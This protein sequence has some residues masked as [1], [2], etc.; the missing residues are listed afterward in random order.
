MSFRAF[1]TSVGVASRV[2]VGGPLAVPCGNWAVFVP[3]LGVPKNDLPIGEVIRLVFASVERF[4]PV[5]ESRAKRLAELSVTRFGSIVVVIYYG[6]PSC[7][8]F[9]RV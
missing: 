7:G 1:L 4:R 3:V 5:A 8:F 9:D 6:Y 2:L